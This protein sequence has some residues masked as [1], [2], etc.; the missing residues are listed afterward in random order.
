MWALIPLLVCVVSAKKAL[1]LLDDWNI[2]DTHSAYFSYLQSQDFELVY[3]MADS[4]HL[5]IEKYGE[6]L[7]DLVVLA[8]PSVDSKS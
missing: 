1:V 8:C 5:K 6:F 7:Y 2:K 3:R 4:S